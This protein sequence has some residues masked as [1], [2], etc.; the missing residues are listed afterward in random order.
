MDKKIEKDRISNNFLKK[1]LKSKDNETGNFKFLK[2]NNFELPDSIYTNVIPINIPDSI[3]KS[4]IENNDYKDLLLWNIPFKKDEIILEKYKMTYSLKYKGESFNIFEVINLSE[5]KYNSMK[6]MYIINEDI[7]S[8]YLKKNELIK[9]INICNKTKKNYFINIYEN[10]FLEKEKSQYYITFMDPI[11]CNIMNIL[12]KFKLGLSLKEVQEVGKQLLNCLKFLHSKNYVFL[13]LIPDNIFLV[14]SEYLEITNVPIN[15]SERKNLNE[16]IYKYKKLLKTDI[17]ITDFINI[18]DI[19]N[20]I[21]SDQY[22]SKEYLAPEIILQSIVDY[23]KCDIWAVGCILMEL[24]TGQKLFNSDKSEILLSLFEKNSGQHYPEYMIQISQNKLLKELFID[25]KIHKQ[26]KSV[27][28]INH[29]NYEEIL[30]VLKKQPN[31]KESIHAQH[32]IFYDFIK[33]LICIDPTIRL[34]AEEALKHKF[35]KTDYIE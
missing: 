25:C 17:T 4:K 12:T 29:E 21:T 16:K 7:K 5:N 23:S 33:K 2:E 31:I 8:S 32:F 3:A 24:Y 11:D 18:N 30:T 13:N 28:I 1:N 27:N 10:I 15:V 20:I 22:I 34:S 19:K 9:G 26:C 6:I 35:F 14:N